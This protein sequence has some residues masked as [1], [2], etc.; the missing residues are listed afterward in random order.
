MQVSS[1]SLHQA[2]TPPLNPQV[3][4]LAPGELAH[5]LR[6]VPPIVPREGGRKPKPFFAACSATVCG[7]K[8][9]KL[10]FMTYASLA[11]PT[12]ATWA[13]ERGRVHFFARQE[14]VA[15]NAE[16]SIRTIVKITGRLLKSGQLRCVVTGRGIIPHAIVVVPGGWDSESRPAPRACPKSVDVHGVHVNRAFVPPPPDISKN[17]GGGTAISSRR[18][19]RTLPRL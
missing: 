3:Y 14:K 18:R 15:T 9:E 7:G 16:C 1:A 13:I 6:L 5:Q 10:V 8:L 11:G 19:G 12:G 17:E 2:A 4:P